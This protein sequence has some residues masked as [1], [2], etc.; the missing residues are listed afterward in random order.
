MKTYLLMFIL[1]LWISERRFLVNIII[2][3]ESIARYSNR[4]YKHTRIVP[5]RDDALQWYMDSNKFQTKG[6]ALNGILFLV[7]PVDQ[8]TVCVQYNSSLRPSFYS[9]SVMIR[10]NKHIHFY[11]VVSRFWWIGR[12]ILLSINVEI[13]HFLN[14]QLDVLIRFHVSYLCIL[15]YLNTCKAWNKCSL[16]GSTSNFER[17]DA[18]KGC[19]FDSTPLWNKVIRSGSDR[20]RYVAH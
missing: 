4:Y 15:S 17:A 19:L 5:H 3:K 20:R 1:E 8:S 7:V 9:T 14:L 11:W 2:I 10:F 16:R 13:Y 18:K 6:S 12:N